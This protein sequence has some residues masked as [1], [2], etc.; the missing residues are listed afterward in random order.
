[1]NLNNTSLCILTRSLNLMYLPLATKNSAFTKFDIQILREKGISHAKETKIEGN[2]FVNEH[3]SL[4]Q[5]YFFRNSDY[6]ILAGHPDNSFK[7]FKD[8]VEL[9]LQI[10]KIHMNFITCLTVSEKLNLIITGSKD[11]RM[12]VWNFD[13]KNKFIIE[14]TDI[15]YGHNCEIVCI[16]TNDVLNVIVSVD[17]D[18]YLMI[19]SIKSLRFLKGFSIDREEKEVVSEVKIHSNG[20]ILAKSKRF[21]YLYK[22]CFD[23][24]V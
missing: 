16:E 23:F 22:Y 7:V 18:G 14:N 19:R 20:L 3:N 8:G 17:K 13:I 9:N 5:S 15:V 10:P 6:V 2:I 24:L 11:C 1:M 12:I 21:L 4:S